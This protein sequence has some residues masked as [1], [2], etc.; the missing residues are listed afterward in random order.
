[1]RSV[2]TARRIDQLGRVVVPAELR[3]I[4][5]IRKGDLLDIRVEDGRLVLVKIEPECAICGG[6][7]NLQSC[8]RNRSA[9]TA[10]ASSRRPERSRVQRTDGA[11]RRTRAALRHAQIAARPSR[12]RR[13]RLAA[14]ASASRAACSISPSSTAAAAARD[15]RRSRAPPRGRAPADASPATDTEEAAHHLLVPLGELAAD[16]DRAVRTAHLEAGLR[17][18]PPTRCGDSNSDGGHVRDRDLAQPLGAGASLA[19]QEPLEAEP[20]GRAAPRARGQRAA[21]SARAPPRPR[22]PLPC[23]RARGAR[24][25]P[26]SRASRRRS[27][28]RRAAPPR[29]VVDDP[30]RLVPFVVP[31]HRAQTV[32]RR[33]RPPRSTRRACGGCPPPRSRPRR[34]VRRPRGGEIAEVADRRRDQH[35]RHARRRPRRRPR[36]RHPFTSTTSP[37]CNPQRSNAACGRLD[38]EVR[39]PDRH[40]RPD[41]ARVTRGAARSRSGRRRRRR[42]GTAFRRCVPGGR[43]GSP[44]RRRARP[45]PSAPGAVAPGDCH[46]GSREHVVP[47]NQPGHDDLTRS[48]TEAPAC[49]LAPA[50]PGT[51]TQA[52]A[53]ISRRGSRRGRRGSAR[54]RRPGHRRGARR[55]AAARPRS[56]PAPRVRG[57]ARRWCSGCR[58]ST[59]RVSRIAPATKQATITALGP[60]RVKPPD[61]FMNAPPAANAHEARSSE[62][63]PG[64]RKTGPAKCHR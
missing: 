43:A 7:D 42:S 53:A 57:R 25:D 14:R 52:A 24:P 61:A 8:T 16:R 63:M 64:E 50:P 36:R 26:R 5:G 3:K 28:T 40:A 35:E 19:G 12:R 31:V 2:G 56:R 10:S 34:A 29:I 60:S 48:T 30:L 39:A 55:G 33:V 45:D 1:M 11:P 27:R 58:G 18:S 13:A 22:S 9:R 4:L 59:A 37:S 47:T 51:A 15:P 23:T 54:C 21:R 17:A 46:L 62:I 32:A 41:A 20:A 6:S 49:H 38:R 44:A